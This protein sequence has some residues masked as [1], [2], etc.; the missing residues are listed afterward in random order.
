MPGLPTRL[1]LVALVAMTAATFTA[2]VAL[3]GCRGGA[4][5]PSGPHIGEYR[6]V[7]TG[8]VDGSAAYGYYAGEIEND[9]ARGATVSL[10]LRDPDLGLSEVVAA[11]LFV[12]PGGSA[13][14][15]TVEVAP[16]EASSFGI[17]EE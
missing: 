12:P 9:G 14:F 6:F 7:R 2:P 15:R 4:L 10:C 16:S 17:C 11:G 5:R 8:P 13:P 1:P 3:S